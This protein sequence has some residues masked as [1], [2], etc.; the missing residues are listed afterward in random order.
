M[1]IS[2]KRK[3]SN[4][5][6]NDVFYIVYNTKKNQKKDIPKKPQTSKN[7]DFKIGVRKRYLP[8]SIHV[9]V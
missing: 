7:L 3:S 5:K 9:H 8:T 2:L 6:S 1:F 4:G